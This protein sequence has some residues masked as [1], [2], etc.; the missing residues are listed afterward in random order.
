ML[1]P[2]ALTKSQKVLPSDG[3]DNQATPP[4][5]PPASGRLSLLSNCP[6]RN[7]S[8]LTPH[9]EASYSSSGH[10]QSFK[11]TFTNSIARLIPTFSSNK[12]HHLN[13]VFSET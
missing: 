12:G 8:R 9:P 10:V 7:D 1:Y 13:C 2:A 4:A 5:S 3:L 6:F 11:C